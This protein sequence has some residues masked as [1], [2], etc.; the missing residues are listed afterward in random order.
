[1]TLKRT[2]ISDHRGRSTTRT[3]DGFFLPQRFV[4]RR[5]DLK[6]D[7]LTLI[8]GGFDANG[9]FRMVNVRAFP[10]QTRVGKKGWCPVRFGLTVIADVQT[11]FR[12]KRR[13]INFARLRGFVFDLRR[14]G[15]KFEQASAH[16]QNDF[17]H[18][19]NIIRRVIEQNRYV[20]PG[21]EIAR[22]AAMP[23][24]NHGGLSA[25]ES[26]IMVRRLLSAGVIEKIVLETV[27]GINRSFCIA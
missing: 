20:V 1:M 7:G 19:R 12:E 3:Q 25:A 9:N 17:G 14:H 27:I 23:K 8:G 2:E 24:I 15:L 18:S 26:F 22:A 6:I 16:V 11:C 13:P 5:D 21:F 10:R 4:P